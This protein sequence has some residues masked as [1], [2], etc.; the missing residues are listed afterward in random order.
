MTVS[1]GSGSYTFFVSSGTLPTG[2]TLN[3]STGAVSGTPTASGTFSIG[4]KDSSGAV[5]TGSCPFTINPAISLTCSATGNTG[6]VGV[7]FSSPAMTVS[8]GTGSYTFFVSS[9]T[10]PT[11]LTLNTST[12]AVSGTPTASGT[13]SI[14]VKDSSGAVATGSCPFTIN[15]AISLTCSTAT[16]GNAGIAFSS[17]ALTV[18][19]G[20]GSYTFFISSGAL[21]TGLTLNTS[22][23]AISGTPTVSGTFSIGVKD[24][25]GTVAT[26]TCPYTIY[27]QISCAAITAYKGVAVSSTPLTVPGGGATGPYSFSATGL[28]SGLTM[29]SSGTISGTPTVTTTSPYTVTIKDGKG[30]TETL[31]CPIQVN[32]PTTPVCAVYDQASPP[33]MTY[34]DTGVGIVRLD[35]TTNLNNNFNVTI[36]PTPTGTSFSPTVPSQPY[37]MPSGEVI[38]FPQATTGLIK[39]SAS[40]INTSKSAQLTVKATNAAGNTVTCDPISTVVTTFSWQTG[41]QGVQTFSNVPSSAHVVTVNNGTPGLSYLLILVNN[42]PFLEQNLTN[43]QVLNVDV[44]SAM[45]AGNNNTIVLTGIGFSASSSAQILISQ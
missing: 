15:P 31:S 37:A 22:T 5:A 16:S 10:L 14:G 19:G 32:T 13:F 26:G 28:P 2:L 33:Y 40:R 30:D 11:G 6:E 39:V 17:P 34:Q 35:V 12:G 21:P 25:S 3:T 1:G 18:S 45:K 44:S 38:L 27:A 7:A 9:G 8:G 24:S 36:T 4:V 41:L 42:V 29:S 20:T 23:G 43:G